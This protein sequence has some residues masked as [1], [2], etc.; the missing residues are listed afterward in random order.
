VFLNGA[1]LGFS[2]KEMYALY[3]DIVEFA[4]LELFMDQK[5]KNYSSGMQVRLAFSIAIKVKSDILI[6]DEVLA[7]GDEAFQRKCNDYFN[8][9]RQDENQ[10]VILVTHSMDS[11]KKYCNKA[12]LLRGGKVV[13]AGSPDEVA[14][15][16]TLENAND[17]YTKEGEAQGMPD[18]GVENLKVKLLSN[19]SIDENGE[20]AFVLDYDVTKNINTVPAFSITDMDRNVWLQNDNMWESIIEGTGHH[21][22]GYSCKLPQYVNNANVK[23]E[24]SVW[25]DDEK[26]LAFTHEK[27]KPKIIIRRKD[28][29]SKHD[30]GTASGLLRVK[31]SWEIIQ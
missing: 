31:G 27:D 12:L 22:I 25:S 13:L 8:Q 17:I 9:I 23:I 16:Y 26:I 1:L 6:F 15:E 14:N 19:E 10:T 4:E 29:S 7:V 5:L 11:V 28:I 30:E 3:P 2:R 24:A 21:K 18:T 20:I